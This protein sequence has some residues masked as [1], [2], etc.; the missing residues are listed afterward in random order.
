MSPID[1]TLDRVQIKLAGG[2]QP[3]V[4]VPT[5]VNEQG[6]YDF[7]LDTGACTCLITEELAHTLA[8]SAVRT[9]A[10][11]GAGGPVSIGFG[12]ANSIAVGQARAAD[13]EIGIT[14]ELDRISAVVGVPILGALGSGF[15]SRFRLLLDYQAQTLELAESGDFSDEPDARE[16]RLE[17][18]LAAAEKPLIMIPVWLNGR[19]PYQFALDTGASTTVISSD[20]AREL[21]IAGSGIP[22]VTGGGGSVAALRAKVDSI[23]VGTAA[24]ADS[25]VVI[26]D[27]LEALSATLGTRLDGILGYNFLRA[28]IVTIDYPRQVLTLRNQ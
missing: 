21:G 10:G 12:S 23:T 4:L 8:I 9:E 27:G 13:V 19:G 2:G 28:F 17:F 1:S 18:H 20:V 24:G 6:P 14:G 15:L 22:R 16:T 25:A 5:Y 11:M 7:V 26:L 3:V